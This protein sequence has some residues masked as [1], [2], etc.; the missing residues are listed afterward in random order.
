MQD[1]KAKEKK[2]TIE[3]TRR[4]FMG[5]MGVGFLGLAGAGSVL[6]CTKDEDAPGTDGATTGD[7]PK[8]AMSAAAPSEV[9]QDMTLQLPMDYDS[10]LLP[11]GKYDPLR[12]A[13]SLTDREL[14]FMLADEAEVTKDYTTPG[15]TVVPA[16][17][18][19]VRNRMNRLGIGLGSLANEETGWNMVMENFAEDEA[20]AYL[21]MPMFNWFT[22]REYS[23]ISHRSIEEC[24]EIADKMAGHSLIIR[25]YRAD[26]PY[27]S[28]MAP[29]WGMWEMNMDIYSKEWCTTFNEGLGADFALAA[30][31][32]V[33]PVCHIVPISTDYVKGDLAPYTDWRETVETNEVFALS[34]CQCRLER[35]LLDI[36]E[37]TPEQHDRESCISLGE[38]AEYY[39]DRG[40]GR[41]ITKEDALA[42]I[43]GNIDKGMIVEK[44]FSKKAEVICQCHSDCCK[45]LSTYY[46]LGGV[47]N[48]M[49]NISA[50]NLDYDRS[51]CIK[52]GSCVKQCPMIAISFDDEGFPQMDVKCVRC[53]QCASVCPVSARS[54]S[55]KDKLLELPEDM[56]DDYQQFSRLRMA[57]GYIQDF[58][59]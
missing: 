12:L 54:L 56:L 3:L 55:A 6:G 15:G 32:C 42:K 1:E 16:L 57:E 33:R 9:P 28:L 58:T 18:V 37:C 17:Y 36:A 10:A 22:V 8:P 47:G 53:G 29:L 23:N 14:D 48:M 19:R 51:I 41:P 59:A 27:Y 25:T 7:A 52:C 34:P 21:E 50:Y 4:N 39:I 2:V 46:A 24:K 30:V 11:N 49:E 44:L 40:I 35:D 31:N 43:Q 20:E 38:A 26:I 13:T 45:L 5:A